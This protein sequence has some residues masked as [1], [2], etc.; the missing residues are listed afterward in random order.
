MNLVSSKLPLPSPLGNQRGMALVIAL[1]MLSIMTLMG[2]LAM[3]TSDTEISISGNYR[4][5]QESFFAADRAVTYSATNP[6]IFLGT[7]AIDLYGTATHKDNI[8]VGR[9]GQ[10]CRDV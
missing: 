7:A 10:R 4:A 5:L 1:V 9:S 8:Q 3:S 6:D 2:M